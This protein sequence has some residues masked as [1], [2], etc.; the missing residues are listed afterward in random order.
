M[1]D[2]F[3]DATLNSQFVGATL[4]LLSPAKGEQVLRHNGY[5]IGIRDPDIKPEHTGQYMVFDP[6]D[7]DQGFC[8]VGDDRNVLI[9]EA[10]EALLEGLD[11]TVLDPVNDDALINDDKSITAEHVGHLDIEGGRDQYLLLTRKDGEDLSPELAERWLLLRVFNEGAGAG[12]H[13]CHSVQAVQKKGRP[14]A[15]ICI[16]E[17]RLDI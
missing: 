2:T 6:S 4:D 15:C 14:S 9:F 1:E 17:H 8:I 3:T 16:V 10:I 13:F 12:T 5:L 11:I 7:D